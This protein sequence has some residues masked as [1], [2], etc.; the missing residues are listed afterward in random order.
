MF[1]V[2]NKTDTCMRLTGFSEFGR[3]KL[4]AVNIS[5]KRCVSVW[6]SEPPC[7]TTG[8][9]CILDIIKRRNSKGGT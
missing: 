2:S 7:N 1:I 3:K 4:G 9:A 8:Y 6:N 5:L